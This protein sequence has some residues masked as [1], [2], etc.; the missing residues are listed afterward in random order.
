MANSL[1]LRMTPY[2][3]TGT[4]CMQGFLE[5][6]ENTETLA[7]MQYAGTMFPLFGKS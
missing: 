4:D 7:T 6:N 2:K 1:N 3:V 5:F